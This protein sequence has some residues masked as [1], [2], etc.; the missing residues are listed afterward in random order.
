MNIEDEERARYRSS[1]SFDSSVL[2]SSCSDLDFLTALGE[3]L[4]ELRTARGMSRRE[5]AGASGVSERWIARIESGK[6]NVTILLLRRLASAF[7]QRPVQP[8]VD[9]ETNLRC[10]KQLAGGM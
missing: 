9:I 6:G 2:S 8:A 5:L 4:R 10:N 1:R 3:R 7:R